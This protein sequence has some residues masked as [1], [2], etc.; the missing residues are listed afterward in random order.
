MEGR[1]NVVM[2]N[3]VGDIKDTYGW[4]DFKKLKVVKP[5]SYPW[6][7]EMPKAN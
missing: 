6:V 1:E 3:V 4:K 5:D 7:M 2:R